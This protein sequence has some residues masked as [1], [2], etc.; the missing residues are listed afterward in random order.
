[1]QLQHNYHLRKFNT[2]GID[3]VAKQFA[4]FSSSDELEEL[5]ANANLPSTFRPL[6]LGGG[7]NILFTKDCN[8]VL[9]NE[10]MNLNVV[11]EEDEYV[12]VKAGAGENWHQLVLYCISKNFGGIENLSLIPGNTGASPMQNIGAYGVELKDVF[13][14]LTAYHLKEKR[15]VRFNASDCDFGYRDSVFKKKYKNLFGA[16]YYC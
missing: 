11:K 7:S 15:I 5:M 3:A 13:H 16:G 9:K 4:R 2:F 1:M 6:I 14:E 12:Y 8:L 10:I